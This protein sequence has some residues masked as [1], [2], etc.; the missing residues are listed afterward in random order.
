MDSGVIRADPSRDEARLVG[1]AGRP[2]AVK[3][4]NF[5]STS[6]RVA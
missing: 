2:A 6:A 1:V 3:L 5:C 4:N